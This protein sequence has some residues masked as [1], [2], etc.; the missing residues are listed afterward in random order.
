MR[1][2][3]RETSL[4]LP[5]QTLRPFFELEIEFIEVLGC[6]CWVE[7]REH[8]KQRAKHTRKGLSVVESRVAWCGLAGLE[9]KDVVAGEES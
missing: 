6:L 3:I 2:I 7:D 9:S 4:L 5:M 8:A 1:G